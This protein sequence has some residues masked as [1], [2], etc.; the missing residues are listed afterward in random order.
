M[1][2]SDCANDELLIKKGTLIGPAEIGMMAMSGYSHVNVYSRPLV[3]VVSTGSELV[4]P[5]K[6]CEE[7]PKNI[8]LDKPIQPNT[9]PYGKI[10]DAN[11]PMVLALASDPGVGNADVIDFGIVVDHEEEN[12]TGKSSSHPELANIIKKAFDMGVNVL[13]T[14][15]GVSVGDRD[16]VGPTLGTLGKVHFSQIWLKPGK[17]LTFATVETDGRQMLVFGVPGNPASAFVTFQTVVVPALRKMAGWEKY[18]LRKIVCETIDKPS[19]KLDNER[20]EFHRAIIL[21]NSVPGNPPRVMSTGMQRSSKLSSLLNADCLMQLPSG[22]SQ[23]E[24]ITNG[25]VPAKTLVQCVLVK[26]LRVASGIS[27]EEEPDTKVIYP[28]QYSLTV[29]T[30]LPTIP[31]GA[32][33]KVE[34]ISPRGRTKE[35]RTRSDSELKRERSPKRDSKSPRVSANPPISRIITSPSKDESSVPSKNVAV[36]FVFI[37]SDFDDSNLVS[38]QLETLRELDKNVEIIGNSMNI[39]GVKCKGS[40]KSKIILLPQAQKTIDGIFSRNLEKDFRQIVFV[41]G[42]SKKLVSSLLSFDKWTSKEVP[43]IG[44]LIRTLLPN[45][46]PLVDIRTLVLHPNEDI[47]IDLSETNQYAAADI[48]KIMLHTL[49][50]FCRNWKE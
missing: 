9:L 20:P 39:Q 35:Y 46:N 45:Q 12:D 44:E 27:V 36:I 13:I 48:H 49:P 25:V 7:I 8:S 11:R 26:D 2:G 19:I 24:Y 17:P 6:N 33:P 50:L 40:T 34:E 5:G 23:K 28:P 3:G 1:V 32:S 15:G 42:S 30:S 4:D 43:G 37:N 22:E 47:L 14:S 16:F 41:L 31:K 38:K 29:Q 18:G 21:P 10:F